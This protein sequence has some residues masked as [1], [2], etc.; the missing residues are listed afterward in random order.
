MTIIYDGHA[1]CFPDLRGDGGFADPTQFRRHVQ[2]AIARHFQPVWRK[3]DRAPA[4]A[5]GLLDPS[6]GSDFGSLKEADFRP[7]GHGRF[8]WSAGGESYAK[9]YIPPSV[10]DMSYP[11]ENLVAE[12][13]YAG[14]DMALLHRTP[15]LGI[16]NEFISDCVRRFPDRLRGLAYVEEWL[17]RPEPEASI[18]K[19]RRAMGELGLH[20]LQ[21]LPDHMPLY[22]QTE[23]WDGPDFKPFW[24]ALASLNVPL[25]ITLSYSSVAAGTTPLEGL[26]GELTRIRH[27][28]EQYPDVRVVLTHGLAWRLFIESDGLNV[29]PEVFDA[30]PLDS[31]NFYLQVLFA[32]FLGGVW[33][34]PMPQV[35]ATME[36]LVERVGTD[37]LMWGTDIPMVMRYYTYRQCQQH[38]RLV[39][40]FLSP[41]EQDM[42]L[43]GNAARVMGPDPGRIA[44]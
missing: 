18:K 3:R 23:D 42:I 43:G 34:Y 22:G 17:I 24:E 26:L 25:F 10:V 6:G 14:V 11:A 8:E 2:L 5:S 30:L 12:M 1:Y 19:L 37:R 44:R 27:W 32:I 33:D 13:D 21:F 35:R 29:P 31:P 7:A 15:Y 9:Q 36:K 4:D 41:A 16:S 20:G 39:C 38:M 28:M 40:D